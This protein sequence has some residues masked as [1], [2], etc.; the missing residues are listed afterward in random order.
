M[1]GTIKKTIQLS[2][3]EG[4]KKATQTKE[5]TEPDLDGEAC[6]YYPV[7]AHTT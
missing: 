7:S 6:L 3:A 5:V 2:K 4:K 1:T